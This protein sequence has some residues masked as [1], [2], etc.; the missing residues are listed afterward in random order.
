[1]SLGGGIEIK[2]TP[3]GLGTTEASQSG[4]ILERKLDEYVFSNN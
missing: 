4:D 3:Q 1:M 2:H